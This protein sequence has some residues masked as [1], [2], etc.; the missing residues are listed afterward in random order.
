MNFAIF[1]HRRHRVHLGQPASTFFAKI[2]LSTSEL[3]GRLAQT[4]SQH[5]GKVLLGRPVAPETEQKEEKKE[6]E[7]EQEEA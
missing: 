1:R 2:L 4:F 3:A 6:E 5:F 7:E